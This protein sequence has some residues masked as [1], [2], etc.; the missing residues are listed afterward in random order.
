MP[1]SVS[2]TASTGVIPIGISEI[3][4]HSLRH[5]AGHLARLQI[6]HEQRLLADQRGDIGSLLFEPGENDAR[7]VPKVHVQP[8]ELLRLRDISD[9]E[10]RPAGF[11]GADD[12][13]EFYRD[14]TP[15]L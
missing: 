1:F 12:I 6:H 9:S 10:D 2:G 4:Q 7:T 5:L 3:E 13:R 11:T 15:T 14:R 8:G